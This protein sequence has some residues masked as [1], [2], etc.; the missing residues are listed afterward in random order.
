MW[1]HTHRLQDRRDLVGTP[2]HQPVQP[3]RWLGQP[4]LRR[5]SRNH[6]NLRGSAHSHRRSRIRQHRS[7]G[8]HTR[9]QGSPLRR[10]QS[11]RCRSCRSGLASRSSHIR[12][13]RRLLRPRGRDR[14]ALR[15][16]RHHTQRRSLLPSERQNL[17][18]HSR[19]RQPRHNRWQSHTAARH[20]IHHRLQVRATRRPHQ[21]WDRCLRQS[22][23]RRDCRNSRCQAPERHRR[24]ARGEDLWS[25][26]TSYPTVVA[27]AVP[28]PKA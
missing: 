14:W 16:R 12:P 13:N 22:H 8:Q 6:S 18:I 2:V 21:S 23:L 9:L 27:G 17:G 15:N 26:A 1:R 24:E 20:Q 4:D 11:Q 10:A 25:R 3:N 28:Q 19:L 5:R 7:P